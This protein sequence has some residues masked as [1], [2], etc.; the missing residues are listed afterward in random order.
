MINLDPVLRNNT[1]LEGVPESQILFFL[2]HIVMILLAV[3][4]QECVKGE[5]KLLIDIKPMAIRRFV[6]VLHP[7]PMILFPAGNEFLVVFMILLEEFRGVPLF[8]GEMTD[9]SHR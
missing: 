7:H 5:P 8:D 1:I 4:S 3:P 2:H 9:L 6:R